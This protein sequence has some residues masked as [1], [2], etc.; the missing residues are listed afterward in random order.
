[1][2]EPDWR[3]PCAP[4]GY[5]L[6]EDGE[7]VRTDDGCPTHS[8]RPGVRLPDVPVSAEVAQW[9]E[10]VPIGTPVL[11]WPGAREGQGRET[12]T[13]TKAWNMSGQPVVMVHG[14]AG[15]IALTHVTPIP[16][17]TEGSA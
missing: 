4:G 8:L 16:N 13:R 17:H 6:F 14:Y 3:Q 11:F 1:M 15:G 10:H 9:N 5:C 2:T 7:V 12:R